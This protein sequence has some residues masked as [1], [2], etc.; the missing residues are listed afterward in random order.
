MLKLY[1]T[2]LGCG[3]LKEYVMNKTLLL[4]SLAF[5]FFTNCIAQET[6]IWSGK[7]NSNGTPTKPVKLEIGQKYRIEVEGFI[8]LGKWHQQKKALANDAC[9]EFSDE[10]VPPVRT[11]MKCFKNSFDLSVCDGNFHEDHKYKSEPFKALQ[12]GIHFWV[13]D[14]NYEDNSGELNVKVIQISPDE[15]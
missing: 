5:T 9:F 8:N 2:L 10:T 7:L 4:L 1:H 15:K 13:Y 12:S 6:A 14:T 3:A 11:K